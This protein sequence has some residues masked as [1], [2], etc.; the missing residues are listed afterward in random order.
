MDPKHLEAAYERAV[1]ERDRLFALLTADERRALTVCRIT[2][3]AQR[4]YEAA[5]ERVRKA[6]WEHTSA[7]FILYSPA[8]NA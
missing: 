1:T 6:W 5:C 3:D 2:T 7:M 4:A 8:P